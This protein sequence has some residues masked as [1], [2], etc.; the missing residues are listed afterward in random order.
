LEREGETLVYTSSAGNERSYW[1]IESYGGG[2]REERI[3]VRCKD[4]EN[5]GMYLTI[6]VSEFLDILAQEGGMEGLIKRAR[7][8]SDLYRRTREAM[9]RYDPQERLRQGADRI[10]QLT[11]VAQPTNPEDG[12]YFAGIPFVR[13]A[14]EQLYGE[15]LMTMPILFTRN[16]AQDLPLQLAAAEERVRTETGIE[17]PSIHYIVQIVSH[18]HPEGFSFEHRWSGQ[19]IVEMTRNQPTR[20]TFTYQTCACHG[21]GL[22]ESAVRALAGDPETARRMAVFTQTTID[23]VNWSSGRHHEGR[24]GDV[25]LRETPHPLRGTFASMSTYYM[26]LAEVIGNARREGRPITLGEASWEATVHSQRHVGELPVTIIDGQ[27][28]ITQ[29]Q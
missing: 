15:D 1:F 22:E 29:Q 18:G 6:K 25:D 7:A 17:E 26:R 13:L 16:P 11:V 12:E 27:R 20:H 10:V 21:G 9:Q 28:F 8:N 5:E 2:G 14:M 4:R 3:V 23:S 19:D 24:P